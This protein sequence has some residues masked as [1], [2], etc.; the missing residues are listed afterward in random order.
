MSKTDSAVVYVVERLRN[1]E[2]ANRSADRTIESLRAAL[3]ASEA[4]VEELRSDQAKT[5][6]ELGQ[7]KASTSHFFRSVAT[8]GVRKKAR[9]K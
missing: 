4:L 5:L 6:A 1:V 9:S 7:V 2:L 8:P 3:A